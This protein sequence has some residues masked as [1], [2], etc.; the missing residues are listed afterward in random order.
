[1]LLKFTEGETTIT[2]LIKPEK[3]FSY[4]MLQ[5]YCHN[6]NLDSIKIRHSCSKLGQL[7]QYKP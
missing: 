6:Y 3:M 1:M 5:L 4:Y 7:A 2:V